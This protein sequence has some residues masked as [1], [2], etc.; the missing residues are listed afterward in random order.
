M[1]FLFD[2]KD[3]MSSGASLR[4]ER[5]KN[6]R[7]AVFV[8][9]EASDLAVDALK[10]A[11]QPQM[12]TARLH[13]EPVVP[14]DVLVVEESADAVIALAGP[15]ASLAP[16]LAQA[17]ERFIPTVVV[18]AGRVPGRCCQAA[19]APRAGHGRR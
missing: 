18:V 6:L 4:T 7:I 3:M 14:G 1:A 10:D 5:E 15:G 19:S 2:I 9:A 11:L 8:D 12:S 16:S 13:I 17:R